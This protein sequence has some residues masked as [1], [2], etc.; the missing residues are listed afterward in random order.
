MQKKKKT[1]G[2]FL[3]SFLSVLTIVTINNILHLSNKT[4]DKIKKYKRMIFIF[5]NS[6]L[7]VVVQIVLL[8]KLK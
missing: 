8:Q 3:L 7:K 5:I 4:E 2:I 1:I 6:I